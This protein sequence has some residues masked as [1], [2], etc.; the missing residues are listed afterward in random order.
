LEKIQK[1]IATELGLS[2]QDETDSQKADLLRER[3][4]KEKI[5]LIIDD[6]WNKI[7]LES[8]GISFGDDQKGSKLLLTSRSED[9]LGEY[10][11]PQEIFQVEALSNNEAKFLFVKIA[12]NLLKP[13]IFNLPWLRLSKNVQ[14]YRLPLQ[15]LQMH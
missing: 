4:K 13:W 10:T 8:R 1:D 7:D 12:G 5:L 11:D 3:L 14:A 9:V 2:F 15:Q 6:I